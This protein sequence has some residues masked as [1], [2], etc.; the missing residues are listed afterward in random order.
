MKK[1]MSNK[2]FTLVELL[3]VVVVLAIVAA[4]AMRSITG[5]I[6]NNRI[7]SFGASINSAIEGA[8][9]SCVQDGNVSNIKETVEGNAVEVDSTGDNTFTV[10]T[11]T[12]GEFAG[13]TPDE[14]NKRLGIKS[15]HT[16][17]GKKIKGLKTNDRIDCG[18]GT[19]KGVTCTV[20]YNTCSSSF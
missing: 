13:L 18:S 3:A 14:V 1:K 19:T 17:E 16:V 5:I 9:L 10:E 8:Q 15:D 4:I 11:T 7:D 12:S 2:G 6:K 20:T